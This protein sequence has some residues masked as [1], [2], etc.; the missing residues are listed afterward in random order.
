M[1]DFL[2]EIDLSQVESRIVYML[3][4][5]PKLVSE[6]QSM[7]W[8]HDMHTENAKLNKIICIIPTV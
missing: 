6:A 5:D 1:V 7:P 2:M 4:R 8:E 3:T